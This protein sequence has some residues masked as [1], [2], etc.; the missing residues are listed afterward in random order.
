MMDSM[1][2]SGLP[3]GETTP[4]DEML[5]FADVVAAAAA[6]PDQ[7]PRMMRRDIPAPNQA[8]AALVKEMHADIDASKQRWAKD[9]ERMKENLRL[10]RL[11]AN[12]AWADAGLYRANIIQE[13]VNSRTARLYARN[14]VLRVER[15]A[16][17]DFQMWDGSAATLQAAA[18][19]PA[20]PA[21]AAIVQDAMQ[22]GMRRRMMDGVARSLQLVAKHQIQQ[23]RPPFKQSMK[24]SVARTLSMGVSFVELGYE[25]HMQPHPDTMANTS[26][27]EVRLAHIERLLADIHDPEAVAATPEAREAEELRL[28]IENMKNQATVVT[29]E[30]LRFDFPAAMSII[31]DRG[32]VDLRGFLGCDRVTREYIWTVD[33]VKEMF[34]VDVRTS[35][36]MYYSDDTKAWPT[37]LTPAREGEALG[38][39]KKVCVWQTYNRKDGLVYWGV[40]GYPDFLAEPAEPPVKLARFWPWFALVFTQADAIPDDDV[41]TPY[42]VS[43]VERI[44]H[45][46]D[47]Y[48]RSR[49]GLRD[50]RI[51][52]RPK[53]VT[54]RGKLQDADKT[55][56]LTGDAHSL[57]ELEGMQPNEKIDDVVQWMKHPGIDPGMYDTTPQFQDIGRVVGAQGADMG[58]VSG[59]TATEVSR[60]AN[61]ADAVAESYVDDLNTFLSELFVEAGRVLLMEMDEA[62]VKKVAGPGAQWPAIPTEDLFDGLYLDIQA[63][64]AGRPN[65]MADLQALQ[66]VTPTLLQIP[67][68]NPSWLAKEMIKRLD[69]NIDPADA[70]LEGIPSIMAMAKMAGGMGPGGP[71]GPGDAPDKG[72]SDGAAKTEGAAAGGDNGQGGAMNTPAAPGMVMRPP[73]N[74][75]GE[76][77]TTVS[78]RGGPMGMMGA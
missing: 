65:R 31:P 68:V 21:S 44:A 71:A 47:E 26:N 64:T 13:H 76:A 74:P 78:G 42:P 75:V 54:P 3:G 63:G 43:D 50:H 2:G 33:Q 12:Q 67:G 46:Q 48:N 32:L 59:A 24:R 29:D 41:V 77:T 60:A 49:Q 30:G 72:P 66:M 8:R 37:A 38:E 23:V 61:S 62:T 52:A 56:L 15:R 53:A 73:A 51:A 17:M 35:G 4:L 16:S 9:F 55:N 14:P 36:T 20:N 10:L 27:M 7:A 19:D 5:P 28:A 58:S 18:M 11:G 34:G 6:N 69:D 25:R 57:I 40:K 1:S 22:G 45:M 70:I 39:T